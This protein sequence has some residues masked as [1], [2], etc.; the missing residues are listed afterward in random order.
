MSGETI[1]EIPVYVKTYKVYN[2]VE[3]T[4]FTGL[5]DTRAYQHL[6]LDSIGPI[7]KREFAH[8]SISEEDWYCFQELYEH[9]GMAPGSPYMGN[10]TL[11][12]KDSAI[13]RE[14][15]VK[16]IDHIIEAY[17]QQ[18]IDFP[19]SHKY[20]QPI[21]FFWDAERNE[22]KNV[23]YPTSLPDEDY[24]DHVDPGTYVDIYRKDSRGNV[25][26][27]SEY[28]YQA[29]QKWHP[30]SVL[31]LSDRRRPLA[32]GSARIT[33][34]ANQECFLMLSKNM[35]SAERLEFIR[36]LLEED[37]NASRCPRVTRFPVLDVQEGG[38]AFIT[39]RDD[40]EN[41]NP[42]HMTVLEK[43]I[44][45]KAQKQ[46]GEVI[47]GD[48]YLRRHDLDN[49]IMESDKTDVTLLVPDYEGYFNTLYGEF[50]KLHNTYTNDT[51][52]RTEEN[53][54]KY[55]LSVV[56]RK[57]N[58][59]GKLEGNSERDI[60]Y[61]LRELYERNTS[62]VSWLIQIAR[63]LSWWLVQPAYQDM[64]YD[65][66]FS[67]KNDKVNLD[68]KISPV[69]SEPLSAAADVLVEDDAV[70][71]YCG[72][73]WNNFKEIV[74]TASGHD[75]TPDECG[76][77]Y[78]AGLNREFS[79]L[80]LYKEYNNRNYFAELLLPTRSTVGLES[81]LL[82]LKSLNGPVLN[83]FNDQYTDESALDFIERMI[84]R[85]A[86]FT[87][88]KKDNLNRDR[89]I[90]TQNAASRYAVLVS[91]NAG[92]DIKLENILNDVI[93]SVDFTL[94]LTAL[95]KDGGQSSE[96][97]D[98]LSA[99]INLAH[100]YKVLNDSPNSKIFLWSN[101]TGLIDMISGILRSLHDLNEGNTASAVIGSAAVILNGVKIFLRV[102]G[103]TA[104]AA[105]S[106]IFLF[107]VA[108]SIAAAVFRDEDIEKW[109]GYSAYGR[110]YDRLS[111]N[112]G[113]RVWG[114]SSFCEKYLVYQ[115]I[116]PLSFEPQTVDHVTEN[117]CNSDKNIDLQIETYYRIIHDFSV[118]IKKIIVSDDTYDVWNAMR[119]EV[120]SPF[121][122]LDYQLRLLLQLTGK[123]GGNYQNRR[124]C[125]RYYTIDPGRR[126]ITY[127]DNG[128]RCRVI[129]YILPRPNFRSIGVDT[130]MIRRM[131][132]YFGD[133]D[134]E[135]VKTDYITDNRLLNICYNQNIHFKEIVSMVQ[136]WKLDDQGR[137]GS[138]VINKKVEGIPQGVSWSVI[139]AD[140][141]AMTADHERSA[142]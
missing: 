116:P 123:Y 84:N 14:V 57:Y 105:S 51:G 61:E 30:I 140:G 137:G 43:L 17:K 73:A 96:I 133:Y 40:L 101:V 111:V 63:R 15:A 72:D 64:L 74:R 59:W 7:D 41:K 121:Y 100:Q 26:L 95:R 28:I 132:C 1:V 81:S 71:A 93:V 86:G 44:M 29:D 45:I 90:F 21:S 2:H 78:V 135:T 102:R 54:L 79:V 25:F 20:E 70:K 49:V 131:A 66:V 138:M 136:L 31:N 89:G 108:I 82:L 126:F 139:M 91:D 75:V 103:L 141:R 88:V 22:Y 124:Q 9:Q 98:L 92:V 52:E 46:R 99:V 19:Y 8:R 83:M 97:W 27:R 10:Y 13:R 36:T 120:E 47:L 87:A 67:L 3:K 38:R 23:L 77:G 80:E 48:Y 117:W 130:G 85:L 62:T 134:G 34:P 94:A 107:S 35:Q 24:I 60:R 58:C 42:Q 32:E 115:D 33:I 12:D 5:R 119:F 112:N 37:G 127:R 4:D 18:C 113:E 114:W 6:I 142:K 16:I 76:G 56:C 50:K 106:Y 129:F 68:K 122:G 11:N 125:T 65:Y 110:D 55:F 118:D 104:L 69:F 53:K 39:P 128:R 109:V